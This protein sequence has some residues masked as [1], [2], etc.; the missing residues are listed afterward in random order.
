MDI[1]QKRFSLTFKVPI[2]QIRPD[3]EQELLAI[4]LRDG[5]RLQTEFILLDVKT[6]QAGA[7]YQAPENWWVG[8]EDTNWRVF[9]LHGFA[10]RKVGAHVGIT[11]VSADK[12]QILWQHN[13]AVFYGLVEGGKVLAQPDKTEKAKFIAL[14]AHSGAI[15]EN[16]IPRE[17]AEAA[18]AAFARTRAQRGFYPVPY[19]VE[20]EYFNLLSRFVLTRTGRQVAG[21]I[22]YLEVGKFLILSYYEAA[23]DDKWKNWLG[24][25]AAETGVLVWEQVINDSLAGWGTSSFFVMKNTLLFI[26]EKDTLVGYSF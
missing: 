6:G 17:Q 16:A 5:D 9:F 14:D 25:F 2:W 21:I 15:L 20:S 18:V 26:T 24:L 3:F 4:E 10:D 8:L 23:P 19:P 11:A 13:E 1:P 12:Q 22:D 7:P